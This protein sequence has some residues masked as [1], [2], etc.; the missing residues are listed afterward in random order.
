MGIV[1]LDMG[2][3]NSKPKQRH[4]RDVMIICSA[5]IET[6]NVKKNG[7]RTANGTDKRQENRD[8]QRKK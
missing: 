3:W 2:E 5:K 4:K 1:K 8:R 6:G 7:K